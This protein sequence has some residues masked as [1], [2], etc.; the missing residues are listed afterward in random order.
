MDVSCPGAVEGFIRDKDG[1]DDP[2]RLDVNYVIL[3]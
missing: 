2:F 1:I 3:E